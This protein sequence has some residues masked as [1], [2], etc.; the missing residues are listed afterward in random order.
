MARQT[1]LIRQGL[2][3]GSL[4]GL[5]W[6]AP[7]LAQQDLLTRAEVYKVVNRV[8]LLLRNRTPRPAKLTD[9]L[10]PQ[11][12]IQTATRSKAELLF[13]EGSLARIGA[14]AV[15]RFIPGMRRFQLPNGKVMAEA[16][17]Q[18]QNGTA[19]ILSPPGST[20]TRVETPQSRIA[21]IA[22]APPVPGSAPDIFSPAQRSN[23]LI[24]LHDSTLNKTQVFALTN[25][26]ITVS[27]LAGKNIVTL[28][29]GQTV[30]VINGVVG[31]VQTFDL[32]TFYQTGQLAAGLGPEQEP[33]VAAEP[34]ALQRTFNL[35][36]PATLEAVEAQ[37]RWVE[38]L[39]TLNSRAGASTLATNCITTDAN[40]PLRS[41][42][43]HREVVTPPRPKVP[44]QPLPTT[45]PLST[46]PPPTEPL[47]TPPPPTQLPP[48]PSPNQPPSIPNTQ[49]STNTQPSATGTVIQVQGKP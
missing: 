5:S 3:A 22:A 34:L 9:V 41:F 2:I 40:D 49:P 37:A 30:S 23:G 25:G 11:D 29:G 19:L 36:R 45:P 17:F 43:D 10:A 14:N 35:V 12:A 44:T 38:G 13:N 6:G 4:I 28:Q 47:P 48:T 32:K 33:L 31:P 18:L 8:Q 26:G 27:D 21:V 42:Q 16:I 24:A 20:G 15:F 39:C 1:W 7:V 46:P